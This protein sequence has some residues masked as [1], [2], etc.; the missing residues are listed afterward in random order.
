MYESA[1][2]RIAKRD[3]QREAEEMKDI[4]EMMGYVCDPLPYSNLDEHSKHAGSMNSFERQNFG[5]V[6][7]GNSQLVLSNSG[8]DAAD[9]ESR[10]MSSLSMNLKKNALQN[11]AR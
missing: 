11:A 5:G 2:A 4:Y 3:Q 10:N 8:T 7:R 6:K 1:K 9:F